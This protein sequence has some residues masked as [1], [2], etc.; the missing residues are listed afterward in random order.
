MYAISSY[1]ENGLNNTNSCT[2]PHRGSGKGGI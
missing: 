2:Q 1:D